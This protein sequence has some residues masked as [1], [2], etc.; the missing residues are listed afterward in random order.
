MVKDL[1]KSRFRSVTR[2][3]EQ[4]NGE[5]RFSRPQR[6]VVVEPV[7]AHSISILN[8]L[9]KLK[10]LQKWTLNNAYGLMTI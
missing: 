2:Q 7:A 3:Y 10:R 8:L 6:Q 5:A 4:L 1:D 9:N